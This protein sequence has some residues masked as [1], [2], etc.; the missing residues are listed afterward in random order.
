MPRMRSATQDRY[1]P[2]LIRISEIFKSTLFFYFFLKF[3]F[4]FSISNKLKILLDAS[5][6]LSKSGQRSRLWSV[7]SVQWSEQTLS[8]LANG[9]Q[10]LFGLVN[11]YY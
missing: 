4:L 10:S 2:A 3:C 6:R 11:T 7:P 1:W 5:A 9:V 8:S